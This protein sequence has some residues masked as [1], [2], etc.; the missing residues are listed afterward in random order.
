M[1][2]DVALMAGIITLSTLAAMVTMPLLL[3]IL[4]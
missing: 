2:G 3:P 1:G 4:W